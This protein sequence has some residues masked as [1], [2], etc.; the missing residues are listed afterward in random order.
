VVEHLGAA[1][2]DRFRVDDDR[3]ASLQPS[4]SRPHDQIAAR[5]SHKLKWDL[6]QS[7]GK[8]ALMGP[9]LL[10]KSLPSRC[11]KM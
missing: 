9:S 7:A 11:A 8:R 10:S 6:W 1:D 2:D 3:P 5:K 4:P